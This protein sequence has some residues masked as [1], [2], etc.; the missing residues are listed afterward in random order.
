MPDT[1]SSGRRSAFAHD[2]LVRM[3]PAADPSVIGAAVTVALCG[4]WEHE[5]P[6]PLAPH[7]TEAQRQGDDVRV[8]VLFATKPDQEAEVRRRIEGA[9]AL[10]CLTGERGTVT[11]WQLVSSGLGTLMPT[12]LEHA[13]RLVGGEG[14]AGD[15]TPAGGA[16]TAE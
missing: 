15:L 6:C 10:R 13:Q 8:R 9:L 5:P 4:H 3:E 11:A 16:G 1:A 12:E 7:H 14:P 2:A